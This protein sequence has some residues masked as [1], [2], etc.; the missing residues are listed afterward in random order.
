VKRSLAHLLGVVTLIAFSAPSVKAIGPSLDGTHG[1]LRIHSADPAEPGYVVAGLYGLY[2]REFYSGAESPRNRSEEVKF[3][4]GM[5]SFGYAPNEYVELAIRGTLES[6]FA[7]ATGTDP[8]VDESFKKFGMG[9]IAFNVKSL[10]T[11]AEQKQWMLGGEVF[12]ATAT[13]NRNALVGSWD[14]DGLDLGGRLNLTWAHQR[15][16]H[17]PSIRFHTN[18]GYLNRTGDFNEAARAATAEGGTVARSV[19]HGDQFLYGAG[20]EVPAAAS[21]VFFTEW[22]GEY[23]IDSEADFDHNPMRVTPGVRWSNTGRSFVWTTGY[24]LRVSSEESGPPWQLVSG[25]S[26]GS[27]SGGVTG[28]IFGVVRDAQTG[29]PIPNVEIAIRNSDRLPAVSDTHGKFTTAIPEGYAVLELVAEGYDSKTRVVEV[30][31]HGREE[32]EFALMPHNVYGSLQGRVRDSRTGV[33][34]AARVRVAGTTEWITADPVTGAYSIEQV[35]EGRVDL[36]IEADKYQPTVVTTVVAAG[37]KSSQDAMLQVAQAEA[38][39]LSGYV[40]DQQ[41]GK[42]VIATVTAKGKQ[43]ATATSDPTTGL[44]ELKLEPGN[45]SVS[46]ASGGYTSQVES[47]QIGEAQAAVQ[48][49]DLAKIPQKMTLKNVFFDSG[50]ATIKRE[51]YAAL[52]GAAKFLT[53]NTQ[54]KV[55]IQGHTDSRGSLA[56]NLALSQRRADAIKKFLVVNYGVDPERLTTIGIGSREPI[57][58]NE[59]A[60]GRALNRRIEFL[61]EGTAATKN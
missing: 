43:T 24:E 37:E 54:L 33:P 61:M 3:G 53:D 57:A 1:L 7:N 52:E 29:E 22:T 40:H 19:L 11:P 59:T 36:E 60:E 50:T 39:T 14:T 34:I 10:L 21:W 58:G 5:L 27:Y 25:F 16:N 4:A 31:P 55:V 12:L 49:F 56:G 38:G 18:V 17:A 44:F 9:D 42:P 2:A 20:L 30:K 6:Q 48:N 8:D 28:S 45:Y 41:T 51:S 15:E 35:R 32:L 13:G 46:V 47:I 26:I 23:D